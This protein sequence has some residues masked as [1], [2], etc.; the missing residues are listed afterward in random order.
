VEQ[1]F[2]S[3][4]KG[5]IVRIVTHLTAHC[6]ASVWDSHARVHVASLATREHEIMEE[7]FSVRRMPGLYNED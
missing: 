5:F 4:M 1:H 6:I 3:A 7:M 2:V